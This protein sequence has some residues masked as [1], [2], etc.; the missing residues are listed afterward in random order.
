MQLTMEKLP[1]LWDSQPGSHK[2]PGDQGHAV[3]AEPEEGE[4]LCVL[5]KD[6]RAQWY[7]STLSLN[8]GHLSGH[9]SLQH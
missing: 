4:P 6:R 3:H 5:L 1:L 2:A 7:T 9:I 8:H